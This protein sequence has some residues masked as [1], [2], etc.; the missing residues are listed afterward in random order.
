MTQ[1]GKN[2]VIRYLIW[3]SV[4][5]VLTIISLLFKG[6]QISNIFLVLAAGF[7][8]LSLLL[9]AGG[10][11][12]RRRAHFS[13]AIISILVLLIFSRSWYVAVW[14]VIIGIGLLILSES[15]DYI[16]SRRVAFWLD[17]RLPL[18]RVVRL[19][20]EELMAFANVCVHDRVS[21][22]P[23]ERVPGD[24]FLLSAQEKGKK[25]FSGEVRELAKE[26]AVTSCTFAL[27]DALVEA[28]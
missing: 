25:A 22:R 24:G 14:L 15:L 5:I 6:E 26:D 13:L 19:H 2:K 11:V 4:V 27:T 28:E 23:G 10:A 1:N 21:V 16:F 8:S 12:V 7:G 20:R 9:V 3:I 18:V 17:N